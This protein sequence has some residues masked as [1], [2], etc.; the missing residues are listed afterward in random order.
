MEG[1][2]R[3]RTGDD[4]DEA[5]SS[6]SEPRTIMVDAAVRMTFHHSRL[7][8]LEAALCKHASQVLSADDYIARSQI[9]LECEVDDAS[10][11]TATD[12]G[13]LEP[14]G[15][16]NPVPRLLL[17]RAGINDARTMGKERNHLK[18]SL[19]GRGSGSSVVDA[20]GF[21]MGEMLEPLTGAIRADIV[22]ELSVNEWK[23]M[24]KPQ[25]M[26]RDLRVSDLRIYDY[27]GSKDAANIMMKQLDAA[28]SRGRSA[29]VV[30]A[31][32]HPNRSVGTELPENGWTAQDL[33]LGSWPESSVRLEETL[34]RSQGIETIYL[35][36]PY[37]RCVSAVAGSRADGPVVRLDT[38]AVAAAGRP[39]GPQ[40]R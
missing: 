32:P 40:S 36:Y 17:R 27:R 26:I 37:R 4:L 29:V 22:G 8:E 38:Q 33:F 2:A 25:L 20:V 30:S 12:L 15:N 31:D 34:R 1:S 24:R 6:R 19:S 10:L 23:G 3:S 7:E 28:A 39:S 35:L 9:D 13:K 14:F 5:L 18:L 16:G 21:G 11:E